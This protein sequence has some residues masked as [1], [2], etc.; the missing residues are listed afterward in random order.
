MVNR[1]RNIRKS[2]RYSKEASL[3]GEDLNSEKTGKKQKFRSRKTK[4]SE[5]FQGNRENNLNVHNIDKASRYVFQCRFYFWIFFIL[6]I[7][8][9]C[10]KQYKQLM[11]LKFRMQKC[12]EISDIRLNCTCETLLRWY[13][14][15]RE[16][17]ILQE[18]SQKT[19]IK[20]KHIGN[21][22]ISITVT[23][24]FS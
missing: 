24:P 23:T 14:L 15:Y 10:I 19:Y 18:N 16:L 17:K 12:R 11:D 8:V 21:R 22:D 1:K 9:C 20:G 5:D 4:N 6:P 7:L 3:F 2:S 13:R